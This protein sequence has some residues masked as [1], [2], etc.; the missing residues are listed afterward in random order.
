MKHLIISIHLFEIL[1]TKVMN[2][3]GLKVTKHFMICALNQIGTD[4]FLI[5]WY[6]TGGRLITFGISCLKEFIDLIMNL[7]K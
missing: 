5:I 3:S 6:Q 7:G 4:S 1:Y 2:R